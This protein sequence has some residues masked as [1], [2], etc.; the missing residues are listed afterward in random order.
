DQMKSFYLFKNVLQ[1]VPASKFASGNFE[2]NGAHSSQTSEVNDKLTDAPGV[3]AVKDVKQELLMLALPAIF[4]QAIDPIVL[5]LETAYIGRLGPVELG[6]AGVSISLFNI[7]SKL[8]NIPL[9]SVA[10][11]F[12]AEDIAKNASRFS[13]S[14]RYDGAG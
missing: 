10:T 9:L 7:I 2:L 13:T 11:S 14:G 3:I 12:V 5:L 1:I 4:G 8:F 6:S